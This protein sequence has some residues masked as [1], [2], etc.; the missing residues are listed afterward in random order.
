MIINDNY[1]K[2]HHNVKQ[3]KQSNRPILR[4]FR[5]PQSGTEDHFRSLPKGGLLLEEHWDKKNEERFES[6]QE[7]F[8]I[9]LDWIMV[10]LNNGISVYPWAELQYIDFNIFIW[11]I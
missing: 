6:W 8:L 5:V 4:P 3:I 7:I 1:L 10:S 11:T 9:G 2:I